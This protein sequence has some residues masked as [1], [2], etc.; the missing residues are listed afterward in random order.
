[1]QFDNSDMQFD[2]PINP[3]KLPPLTINDLKNAFYQE[4]QLKISDQELQFQTDVINVM[5]NRIDIS[6]FPKEKQEEIKNYYR[7]SSLACG[8]L[9]SKIAVMSAQR[10]GK[11]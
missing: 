10:I 11:G 1:M 5:E 2:N 6:E 3:P 7:Y 9:A 4:S 8:S